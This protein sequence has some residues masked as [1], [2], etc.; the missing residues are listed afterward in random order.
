M[1]RFMKDF[2]LEKDVIRIRNGGA[3]SYGGNQMWFRKDRA[4]RDRL[5]RQGGCGLIASADFLLYYCRKNK[6][7]PMELKE[8]LKDPE[9]EL[10]EYLS[11]IRKSSSLFRYP[12]FPKIGS[13]SFEVL[14][15][16]NRFLKKYQR[17]ERMK[18]LYLNTK[19]RRNALVRHAFLTGY[20]LILI[21]GQPFFR[22]FS[23]KGVCFYRLQGGELTE[24]HKNVRR[25]FVTITG[26]KTFGKANYYE[27]TSWGQKYFIEEK[28][29]Q[30]YMNRISAPWIS[31]IFYLRS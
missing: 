7:M 1:I 21:I 30:R 19:K 16:I 23:K 10:P 17:K 8:L 24:A 31:S 13:F 2:T 12:V 14:R 25:H 26:T 6:L 28:D 3:L 5:L 9:P 4:Y 15:F 29:L 20:P 22:P 18:Y 11:F 27:I